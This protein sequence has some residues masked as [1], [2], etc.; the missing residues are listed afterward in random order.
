MSARKPWVYKG[1]SLFLCC[2][3]DKEVKSKIM[4]KIVFKED[5]QHQNLILL[6]SLEE[7]IPQVHPARVVSKIE[8]YPMMIAA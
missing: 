6:P 8:I 5:L 3:T 2:K 4:T 1:F 7:L